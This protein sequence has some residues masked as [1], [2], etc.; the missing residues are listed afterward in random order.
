MLY[1]LPQAPPLE[2]HTCV[3]PLRST[4][5]I[6]CKNHETNIAY[7]STAAYSY[8]LQHIQY[9]C[10][11][12]HVRVALKH[13]CTYIDTEAKG[14]TCTRFK[15]PRAICS[16]PSASRALH[17]PRVFACRSRQMRYLTCLVYSTHVLKKRLPWRSVSKTFYSISQRQLVHCFLGRLKV[18]VYTQLRY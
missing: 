12:V 15:N 4:N 9:T 10:I 5:P 2:V 3:Q 17:S 16:D 14:S 8:V 1:V 18:P 6:H 11:H 13:T 7:T